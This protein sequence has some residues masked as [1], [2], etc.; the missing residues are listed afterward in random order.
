MIQ[1]TNLNIVDFNICFNEIQG[2]TQKFLDSIY[3]GGLPSNA[4]SLG[5]M[6]TFIWFLVAEL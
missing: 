5:N 2:L 6:E 3:F 4:V 1:Y